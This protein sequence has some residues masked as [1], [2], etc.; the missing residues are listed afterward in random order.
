MGKVRRIYLHALVG[1]LG[2]W[3]GWM[4]FGELCSKDAPW[5]V[6]ALLGGALIGACIGYCIAAV[7]GFLDRSLLRFLRLAAVGIVL[8]ALG[9]AAGF[10]AG[11]YVNLLI[12]SA[13]G[14]G[15]TLAQFCHV[16]AR[17]L[18]W[19]LFGLAVGMSEGIAT[20]SRRKVKYGAI[21][22]SLG[23]ALAGMTFGILLLMMPRE[24]S[25]LWGQALGL[26]ILGG[27]IGALR[28]L[29]EEVMKPAAVR[30]VLGWQEGREYSVTKEQTVLGRD[31]A[32][33]VLL[34]RDRA[35]AK[36]H[37]LL[38]RDGP[39]FWLQRL[40]APPQDLRVNDRP[41]D[42]QVEVR[43]GDRIQLGSTVIRFLS[44]QARAAG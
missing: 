32:V 18:G 20:R 33:D 10:Y 12:V 25:Y 28:A 6:N 44:R 41:I 19:A 24:A 34:L 15:S 30:V 11:D 14:A 26:L 39:R 3:L 22:G 9:G 13:A 16:L 2:G 23:G 27:L 17:M 42:D 1:A 5:Q 38:R 21:G 4:L 35:V 37:A 40:D 29:V 8:G 36:R 7:E 31:E 43:D